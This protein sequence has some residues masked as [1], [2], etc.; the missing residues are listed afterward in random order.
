VSLF[1]APILI[2]GERAVSLF[3]GAGAPDMSRVHRLEDLEIRRI[4]TD[5]LFEGRLR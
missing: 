5:V 2:G 1:V 3:G 4:G